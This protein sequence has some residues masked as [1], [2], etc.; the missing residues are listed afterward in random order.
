MHQL[1]MCRFEHPFFIVMFMLLLSC[2]PRKVDNACLVLY[3]CSPFLAMK[4][5]TL[6]PRASVRSE[7]Q[8]ADRPF[9]SALMITW[10][11]ATAFMAR[12]SCLSSFL[13]TSC[14]PLFALQ[15]RLVITISIFSIVKRM[16]VSCVHVI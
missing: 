16:T 15:Q 7:C 2:G 12:F 8:S 6:F 10:I 13:I 14:E 5:S 3:S 4:S 9:T 1:F 11:P